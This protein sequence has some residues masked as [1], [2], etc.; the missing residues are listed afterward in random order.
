MQCLILPA[1]YHL[2]CLNIIAHVNV[3]TLFPQKQT[4]GSRSSRV[5]EPSGV[6]IRT[7]HTRKPLQDN[8]QKPQ[9]TFTEA[10]ARVQ[11]C[12]YTLRFS[13]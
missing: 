6:S 11:T 5:W 2:L 9:N 1:I 7:E 3:M 13:Y 12:P 10:T 8:V 4:A